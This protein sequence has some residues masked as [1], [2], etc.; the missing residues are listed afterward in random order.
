MKKKYE[1]NAERQKAYRHRVAINNCNV[2][3]E[4]MR[5]E[6]ERIK[7][8]PAGVR[9]ISTST[10]DIERTLEWLRVH[11]YGQL[12]SLT[13]FIRLRTELRDS[14]KFRKA[15]GKLLSKG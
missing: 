14:P 13:R 1:S 8:L 6:Q 2:T 4:V 3:D 10:G 15:A 11:E 5:A 12:D 9:G 7:K